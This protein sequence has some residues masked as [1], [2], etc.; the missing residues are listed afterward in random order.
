[1]HLDSP[2]SLSPSDTIYSAELWLTIAKEL[3]LPGKSFPRGGGGGGVKVGWWWWGVVRGGVAG[4]AAGC[5][6]T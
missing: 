1:M 2:P 4:G 6:D 3:Y 5:W